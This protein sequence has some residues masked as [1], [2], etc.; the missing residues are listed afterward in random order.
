M[1]RREEKIAETML[2]ALR[3]IVARID[4][5]WDDPDL[6]DLGPLSLNM[7]GDVRDFANRAIRG[8]TAS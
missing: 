2:A 3:A 8:A 7:V 6:V 1:T 5:V 4:G